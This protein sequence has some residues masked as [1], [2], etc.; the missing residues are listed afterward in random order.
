VGRDLGWNLSRQPARTGDILTAV[1]R[2]ILLTGGSGQLGQAFQR[3]A[4]GKGL[5]VVA[6]DREQLDLSQAD[7]IRHAVA[8]GSWSAIVNCGAYTAVDRA[9]TDVGLAYAINAAAPLVLA[10]CAKAHGIPVL[11]LSTDYVFDGQKADPYLEDDPVCPIN[12]YG[13]SKAKGESAIRSSG[14]QYAIIR[15]AWVLSADGQNFLNTMLRLA[16]ERSVIDVVD[17][18]IG[19]PTSATDLA[20]ALCQ[21]LH[22]LGDRSGIWHFVNQGQASWHALAELIF[23]FAQGKGR[24]VPSVLPVPSSAFPTAAERPKN[25]RLATCGI[26]RDFGIIPRPWQ[27]AITDILEERLAMAGTVA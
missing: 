20:L 11:H 1:N 4:S 17:D 22:S 19:C 24:A 15:T 23:H 3:V 18:Q 13:A 26:V 6:P 14:A 2:S 7:S 8:Q 25:S 12:V 16:Q 27:D 9:E 10:E 5:S 21:I